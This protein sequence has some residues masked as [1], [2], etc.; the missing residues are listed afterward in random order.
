MFIGVSL[1]KPYT[2]RISYVGH[3]Y[4]MEIVHDGDCEAIVVAIINEMCPSA[5][6]MEDIFI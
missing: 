4:G 1:S 2:G 3:V 6:E 5:I